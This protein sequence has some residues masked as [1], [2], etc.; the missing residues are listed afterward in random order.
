MSLN[1]KD[2][3]VEVG[4][5][6]ISMFIV[7]NDGFA[8]SDKRY[9][10]AR[11]AKSGEWLHNDLA[12]WVHATTGKY[13]DSK[14]M[15]ATLTKKTPK[16]TANEFGVPLGKKYGIFTIKQLFKR[17]GKVGP[18]DSRSISL[19]PDSFLRPS[20]STLTIAE[21]RQQCELI[22]SIVL[23]GP[24]P[25]TALRP[26]SDWV[27]EILATPL[28]VVKPKKLKVKDVFEIKKGDSALTESVIYAQFEPSGLPVYGGGEA[29]PRFKISKTSKTKKGTEITVH[30]GPALIV[31]MDGSSGAVRVVETGEFCSNHHA[32]VLKPKAGFSLDLYAVAQQLE[33]GL[34]ELSSNKAGSATL[35]LPVLE[36]FELSLPTDAAEIA[37][38]IKQRKLVVNIRDRF[39]GA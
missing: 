32:S 27:R 36:E 8:N 10:T 26:L 7:D 35:T 15:M 4:N 28:V 34:R 25:T 29:L 17:T 22:N 5:E 12:G 9:E 13:H 38:M 3:S 16:P 20:F 33:G 23:G 37:E 14:L 39:F 18:V 2:L 1:W 11:R 30:A 31:A 21:F 6:E 24:S 19:L